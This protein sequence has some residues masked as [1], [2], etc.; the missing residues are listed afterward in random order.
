MEEAD[1]TS[2]ILNVYYVPGAVPRAGLTLEEPVWVPFSR[3]EKAKA[4]R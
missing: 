3:E 2:N 1:N 4:Q